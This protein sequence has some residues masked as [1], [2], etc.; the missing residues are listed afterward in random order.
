MA[1]SCVGTVRPLYVLKH[2][3][4]T[5]PVSFLR[6]GR[7][8]NSIVFDSLEKPVQCCRRVIAQ[9]RVQ[10]QASA[11]GIFGGQSSSE[12]PTG[13]FIGKYFTF[14]LVLSFLRR[15]VF[16]FLSLS[17]TDSVSS[18]HLTALLANALLTSQGYFKLQ[19]VRVEES[20]YSENYSRRIPICG[21][22]LKIKEQNSFPVSTCLMSSHYYV[23][24]PFTLICVTEF[25]SSSATSAISKN[26]LSCASSHVHNLSAN[27]G[28]CVATRM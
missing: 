12:V 10:L 7:K 26:F 1:F 16:T 23:S 19:W 21:V 2:F 8:E 15:C 9:G 5:G 11:C 13:R 20:P 6:W 27:Q 28:F 14:S 18:Q 22:F 3:S 24:L 4:E 17:L 25:M